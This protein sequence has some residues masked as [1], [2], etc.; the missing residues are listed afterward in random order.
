M[1]TPIMLLTLVVCQ[2]TGGIATSGDDAAKW[3]ALSGKVSDPQGKP[4]AGVRVD[5]STAAPKVGRGIFCPSCYLDCAKWARTDEAGEFQLKALDPKLKFRLLIAAP[6]RKTVQTEL[7]DPQVGPVQ[8]TL[9]PAPTDVDRSRV[10][11]GVVTLSG[12]AVPGALVEPTGGKNSAKRWYGR[13]DGVDPAVTDESGRFAMILPKGMLAL[14]IEVTGDGFCGKKISSLEPGGEAVGIEVNSGARVTGSV[15]RF[16]QPVAGMSLAVVQTDR[17]VRN[18]IFIAA[19]GDVTDAQGWFEF[20]Y[21]PSDQQYCIYSVVGDARRTDSDVILTTKLFTV[22]SAGQTRDLGALEAS[23][24]ISIRGRVQRVDDKPL[25]ENL[26]LSFG[27]E[28]A[29]DL[30]GIPVNGDGSFAATGL[31][32]ETYEIRIGDRSLVIVPDNFKY[33]A[34]GASSFGINARESIDNLVIPVRGQ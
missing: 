31:P 19:V 33:Q 34:L 16:G 6:G 3:S 5:I 29:W 32:P 22:P 9:P 26:K 11:S 12:V 30:I 27:R 17:S 21:L 2:F 4:L 13:V 25:P 14:D 10:V 1:R 7:V 24:P 8:I 20:R 28:P 23:E 18:G 15:V